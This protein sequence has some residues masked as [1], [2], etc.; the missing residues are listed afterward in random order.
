MVDTTA[1][2]NAARPYR[3]VRAAAQNVTTAPKLT[4]AGVANAASYANEGVAP[5]EIVPAQHA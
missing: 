2:S 5:G 1:Y 3:D 4:A